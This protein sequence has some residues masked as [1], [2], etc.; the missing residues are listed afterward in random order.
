MFFMIFDLFAN[1]LSPTFNQYFRQFITML[2]LDD[3]AIK[4]QENIFLVLVFYGR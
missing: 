1:R 2:K 3:H 4:L